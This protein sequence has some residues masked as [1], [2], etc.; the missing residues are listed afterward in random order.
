MA[1]DLT[2]SMEIE[3][4][5]ESLKIINKVDKKLRLEIGRDIKRIGEKTVV[6]AIMEILPPGAP[7]SGM[8]HRK[9]TGWY[10]SKNKGIKVK[11]NTRGA[12]RRNI[13]KGAQYE[14]LAVITVQT[15]GAALAMMDMAGKG[16]NQ[17]RNS[18]PNR[19]RPNFVQVLNERLGGGPSRFMWR[20]GEK[21][22]PDFQRELGPTI[23]R[24][25]YRS[26]QELMKV[27]L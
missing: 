15:T 5:K 9:R 14:T 7:M 20:G 1:V 25:I 10:N 12:R 19:A 6:A 22:I 2:A 18:N 16:P 8:E 21:A 17:T 27:K 24:V 26:N 11:T 23:D 4:L 3:G 13:E